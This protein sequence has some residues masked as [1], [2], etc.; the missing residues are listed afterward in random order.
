MADM[1]GEAPR[2]RVPIL[3][4]EQTTDDVD[5]TH[6]FSRLD[7]A[8]LGIHRPHAAVEEDDETPI[9]APSADLIDDDR[10]STDPPSF[11]GDTVTMVRRE[12]RDPGRKR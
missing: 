12:R 7:M 5:A 4:D 8:A 10:T 11:V 6:V 3:L 2:Q 1:E 9:Y